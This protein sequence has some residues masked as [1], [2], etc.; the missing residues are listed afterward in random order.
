MTR[1]LFT[2]T[3]CLI[4]SILIPIGIPLQYLFALWAISKMFD[5]G[6][7]N[8]IER[9]TLLLFYQV[10]LPHLR[11]R[12]YGTVRLVVAPVSITIASL[13]FLLVTNTL[14][15]NYFIISSVVFLLAVGCFY[16]TF[17]LKKGYMLY[18]KRAVNEN[19]FS[20]NTQL[21]SKEAN[22]CILKKIEKGDPEE[23]EIALSLLQDAD[24]QI[25]EQALEICLNSPKEEKISLALYS[26]QKKQTPN[27][28]QLIKRAFTSISTSKIK[29]EALYALFFHNSPPPP[30]LTLEERELDLLE[31][32][33]YWSLTNGSNDEKKKGEQLLKQWSDARD[34][35]LQI[36]AAT[37]FSYLPNPALYLDSIKSLL[38]NSSEKVVRILTPSFE[39]INLSEIGEEL[40]KHYE[41]P[42]HSSALFDALIK[43]EKECFPIAKKKVEEALIEDQL[44]TL[45]IYVRLVAHMKEE[46][47][48]EYLISLVDRPIAHS[49]RLTIL[50]EIKPHHTLR[51]K[52]ATVFRGLI[53][54]LLTKSRYLQ[55]LNHTDEVKGNE[56]LREVV[57]NEI[58]LTQ[59]SIFICLNFLYPSIPMNEVLFCITNNDEEKKSYAFELLENT[60]PRKEAVVILTPIKK[61]LNGEHSL[62]HSTSFKKLLTKEISF[63]LCSN[64]FIAGML[65]FLKQTHITEFQK[66]ATVLKETHNA[67]IKELVLL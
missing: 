54:K 44:F 20:S 67:M 37:I 22:T 21:L 43:S 10:F 1:C 55:Q 14:G 64:S 63:E 4:I 3:F 7:A 28:A 8:S 19:F 50:R 45:R 32:L 60:L 33:V 25:L 38:K 27:G 17:I 66:L 46:N 29:R 35:T 53:E 18:L 40:L 31:P 51:Q 11:N 48:F 26:L 2:G 34:E 52:S 59:E 42:E 9:Q 47:T 36:R 15:G 61:Y 5:E 12:I 49:Q 39:Y 23:T 56:L 13:L 58:M 30:G 6:L 24:P 65:Y 16:T 57:L 41:N 62:P